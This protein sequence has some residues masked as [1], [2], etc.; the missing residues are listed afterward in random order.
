MKKIFRLILIMILAFSSLTAN[1][2]ILSD[3]EIKSEI[4]KQVVENDKKYTD[5]QLSAHVVA[6]P[7]KELSLPNG[8]I[9]IVVE[10][11]VDKFMA[12]DLE[13][14]SIYLNDSLFKV[15]NAPV[16]VKAYVNVLIA[17]CPINRE[18]T[19]GL[20]VVKIE[21]REVSNNLDYVLNAE[22]LNNEIVAKK[23]FA[24]GEVIDK[25]FVKVKPD[26]LRN[27]GVTVLFNTNN[28]TISLDAIA[29][30]DGVIGDNICIMNKNYNKIY[31]GKIIGENKVLVKI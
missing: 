30:S 1:A 6:L 23:F 25:R 17:T 9:S 28:L 12:R 3:T 19:L 15:F 22:N 21:K 11:P 16:S 4:E 31:K 8:K 27:S 13:K 10:S 18:S 20:N 24:T 2:V 5:A 29:L 26:I 7:F 14:V